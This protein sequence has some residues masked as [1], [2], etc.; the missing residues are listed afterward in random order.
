MRYLDILNIIKNKNVELRHDVDVSISSALRMAV[1]EKEFGI[2]STY[3]LRFDCDYY[4]L[5]TN[6]NLKIVE[7]LIKNHEIGCHVDCSKFVTEEELSKYL[8]YYN[9]IIPFE[10]FT[11][12]INTEKTKSFGQVNNFQ[13]KSILNNEYISDSK[14]NF[15]IEKI[16]RMKSLNNYTLVIHPE[17]WNTEDFSFCQNG[18]E[19]LIL[20][21]GLENL[22]KQ[23][24]KE[25]L[26]YE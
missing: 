18:I 9:R 20:N 12:H 24:L 1:F 3:Y 19:T 14:N 16:E 13:N 2:K 23:A 8:D 7:Y 26:N 22:K 4:N 25:I 5:L 21:L 10:K 17:W 6:D 15:G 11:F